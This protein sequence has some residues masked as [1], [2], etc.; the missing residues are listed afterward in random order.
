MILVKGPK[1]NE[2]R[3]VA[4]YIAKQN[5]KTTRVHAKQTEHWK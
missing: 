3:D 5:A 2:A 1:K 4:R